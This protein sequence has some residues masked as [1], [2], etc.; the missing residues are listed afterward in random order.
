MDK[1][2]RDQGAEWEGP[3]L[4][5]FDVETRW[6]SWCVSAVMARHIETSLDVNDQPHW[7][8][9]VDV[10]GARVRVRSEV[11]YAIVQSTV[12]QRARGWALAARIRQEREST[13]ED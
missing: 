9:F 8:T 7:I 10:A 2:L 12:E 13:L 3:D 6:G 4:D 11:I 5:H 1:V